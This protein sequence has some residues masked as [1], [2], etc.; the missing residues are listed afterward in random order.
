[1]SWTMPS[2][3]IASGHLYKIETKAGATHF[4]EVE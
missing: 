4:V 2:A 1:M 3:T